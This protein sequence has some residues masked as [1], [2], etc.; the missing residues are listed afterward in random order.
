MVGY[1]LGGFRS[2]SVLN[3]THTTTLLP[4]LFQRTV[5][6]MGLTRV[7]GLHNIFHP[8]LTTE[9]L[10]TQSSYIILQESNKGRHP[11]ANKS[12]DMQTTLQR[13]EIAGK[14]KAE[15]HYCPEISLLV[16]TSTG[17]LNYKDCAMTTIFLQK[18]AKNC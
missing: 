1:S 8:G 12:I 15:R 4:I 10:Q 9:H 16:K 6:G 3:L 11:K 13:A 7:W 14:Q 2:L 5:K 17:S 18:N